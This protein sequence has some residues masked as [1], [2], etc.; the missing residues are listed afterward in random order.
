RMR[1]SKKCRL[2]CASYS[3][4]ARLE[5]LPLSTSWRQSETSARRRGWAMPLLR[6]RRLFRDPLV[7]KRTKT[8]TRTRIP[9]RDLAARTAML[10]WKKT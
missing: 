1:A 4:S 7:W 8:K 9:S 3:Q 2:F 6:C 5:T 10:T